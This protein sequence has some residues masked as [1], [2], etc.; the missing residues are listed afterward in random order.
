M[1]LLTSPRRFGA[2]TRAAA[3]R[4][5]DAESNGGS[6]PAVGLQAFE[7]VVHVPS[8]SG[9][10]TVI[11][12]GKLKSYPL[13]SMI[14][15]VSP[16]TLASDA[17]NSLLVE[18]QIYKK[19][20]NVLFYG[21]ITPHLTPC[22]G[23]FRCTDVKRALEENV[24]RAVAASV[25]SQWAQIHEAHAENGE[26]EVDMAA[27]DFIVFEET[28]NDPR[29][30][31][32][33]TLHEYL[34]T[35]KADVEGDYEKLLSIA[36]QVLY[37]LHAFQGVRL[38]HNDLHFG[39]I[40][41]DTST[42][43]EE[44]GYVL[45]PDDRFMVPTHGVVTRVYDFDRGCCPAVA[46]NTGLR[47]LCR[48]VGTC[49]GDNPYFDTFTFVE[50]LYF[51][52]VNKHWQSS[53]LR[54]NL[55]A[56]LTADADTKALYYGSANSTRPYKH[57]MC[58]VVK[59]DIGIDACDG[60]FHWQGKSLPTAATFLKG[61]RCFEPLKS[62][63]VDPSSPHTF[64]ADAALRD[65]MLPGFAP[66]HPAEDIDAVQGPTCHACGAW[67][68]SYA[69]AGVGDADVSRA[70]EWAA[71]VLH[72]LDMFEKTS[73][74]TMFCMFDELIEYV[75][76]TPVKRTELKLVAA[77]FIRK[78]YM[79]EPDWLAVRLG[80]SVT[81]EDVALRMPDVEAFRPS[82]DST[83]ECLFYCHGGVDAPARK[84]LRADFKGCVRLLAEM[85]TQPSTCS[86]CP[87][88]R[89]SRLLRD[90]RSGATPSASGRSWIERAAKK[91][92]EATPRAAL[93]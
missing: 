59:D 53:E 48:S 26:M 87:R 43:I 4:K 67:P 89:A 47:G 50:T 71:S 90:V 24:E 23:T 18:F 91:L 69:G 75:R 2:L 93:A 32:G 78:L 12:T 44:L 42:G 82:T 33:R 11:M 80:P 77:L 45:G 13:K 36:W 66:R 83:I 38:R 25:M 72:E 34:L 76:R 55:R 73:S 88:D 54:E 31:K 7:D 22:M 21:R 52:W 17:D 16:T 40:M 27:A 15:K 58:N 81:G 74:R 19:V 41:V 86:L 62:E 29:V 35:L 65:S 79:A 85:Y 9:S 56:V 64:F 63:L 10:L 6:A 37:T 3:R 61:M 8:N 51:E 14:M 84:L 46:R 49:D 92:R 28:R 5:E 1:S 39:N 30:F 60:E 68:A 20:I 70:L 57:L